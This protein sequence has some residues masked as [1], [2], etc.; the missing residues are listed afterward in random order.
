MA[1][2]VNNITGI[3]N[4]ITYSIPPLTAEQLLL[5]PED[6]ASLSFNYDIDNNNNSNNNNKTIES[7][8]SEEDNW[9][10]DSKSAYSLFETEYDIRTG[11]MN[12]ANRYKFPDW[13]WSNQSKIESLP[14]ASKAS[15]SFYHLLDMNIEPVDNTLHKLY[16][17]SQYQL[18]ELQNFAPYTDAPD[19]ERT[20]TVPYLPH[21]LTR[22]EYVIDEINKNEE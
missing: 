1:R 13:S 3:S 17:P 2:I 6:S 12:P 4:E 22:S 14:T 18:E 11:E 15:S 20:P 19:A 8:D 9:M 7:N 5:L 16:I 10:G 21:T